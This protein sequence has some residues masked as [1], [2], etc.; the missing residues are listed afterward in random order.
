MKTLSYLSIFAF[1]FFVVFSC[2]PK[3]K[4]TAKNENPEQPVY[5]SLD[6]VIKY[7]DNAVFARNA[8]IDAAATTPATK[9][10]D[11]TATIKTS[12]GFVPFMGSTTIS[13]FLG[14]Q[15]PSQSEGGYPKFYS[16]DGGFVHI[17]NG[18]DLSYSFSAKDCES[19]CPDKPAVGEFYYVCRPYLS[20]TYEALMSG[21]GAPTLKII[22]SANPSE[23]IKLRFNNND[24]L[25]NSKDYD[26]SAPYDTMYTVI[27][28]FVYKA[29]KV[30]IYITNHKGDNQKF[31]ETTLDSKS[32]FRTIGIGTSS[33]PMTHDFFAYVVKIGGQF[34]DS[35]NATILA[36]LKKNFPI[37]KR[38]DKPMAFPSFSSDG[39]V[40]KVK[41]NY[42]P[43]KSY[44]NAKIDSAKSVLRWFI[45]DNINAPAD[46]NG[47]KNGLDKQILIK[48]TNC[49]DGLEL[50]IAD[51]PQHFVKGVSQKNGVAI[52][53]KVVDDS[54][55]GSFVVPLTNFP[56]DNLY[57]PK[58]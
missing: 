57:D 58:N 48:T 40:I 51:Y 15:V 30:T 55:A 8:Y 47:K 32:F 21:V 23:Q 42:V 50:K 43:S 2:K 27:Y 20:T 52:D 41:I 9:N 46:V 54:P 34:T 24:F 6:S 37:G 44:P 17:Y 18:V 13:S 22:A 12:K 14:N 19:G 28:R 45:K 31:G 5:E 29:G 38:P 53:I 25:P 49:K 10:G 39:K 26:F 16:E 7:A 11:P 35:Q 3:D 4:D 1:L 56:N 36:T 33:H